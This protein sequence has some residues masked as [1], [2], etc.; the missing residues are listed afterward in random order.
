[1]Y[2]CIPETGRGFFEGVQ[3]RA[4]A[5]HFLR[6]IPTTLPGAQDPSLAVRLFALL[7]LL[8]S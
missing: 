3:V 1:M 4:S 5:T 8:A 7:L 2:A 6:S